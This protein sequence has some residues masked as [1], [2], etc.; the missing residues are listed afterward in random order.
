MVLFRRSVRL[1]AG[2]SFIELC[3]V[4]AVAALLAVLALPSFQAMAD[5][6]KV[7]QAAQSMLLDLRFARSEAIK[8]SRRVEICRADD[9]LACNAA[10]AA[11]WADGW[12]VVAGAEVLRVQGPLEGIASSSSL[13]KISFEPT[14]LAQGAAGNLSFQ[15]TSNPA[16]VQRVCISLQGRARLPPFA[17]TAC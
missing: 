9:G 11:G 6:R 12:I 4:L 14:G 3:M 16:L 8:R 13:V 1:S 10:P 15:A 5:R 7:Q 17:A 2:F